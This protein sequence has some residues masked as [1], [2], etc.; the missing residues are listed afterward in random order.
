[1]KKEMKI[2]QLRKR[3]SRDCDSI[4]NLYSR[5]KWK[6][7]ELGEERKESYVKSIQKNIKELQDV[8]PSRARTYFCDF[9]KYSQWMDNNEGGRGTIDFLNEMIY[10]EYESEWELY[11]YD[12]VE[13]PN[14]Q[15]KAE[16]VEC[17]YVNGFYFKCEYNKTIIHTD[18]WDEAK[19]KVVIPIDI[20]NTPLI[21]CVEPIKF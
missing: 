17:L 19:I 5:N 3:I 9:G 6:L 13:N 18:M 14:E 21:A 4:S 7:D 20:F 8:F 12:E 11:E 1:M 16:I 2:Y 15:H 10:G